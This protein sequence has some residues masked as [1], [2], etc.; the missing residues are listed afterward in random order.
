ME[1]YARRG[2]VKQFGQFQGMAFIALAIVCQLL[3]SRAPEHTSQWSLSRVD[4]RKLHHALV[5]AAPQN[6][7]TNVEGKDPEDLKR[8]GFGKYISGTI[9]KHQWSEAIVGVAADCPA[10]DA[11]AP[12]QR[13]WLL[14]RSL[15]L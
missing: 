9:A 15:L 10:E 1:V 8:N 5:A 6:P 13:L 3:A 2:S 11:T 7:F 4:V 14:N 12:K